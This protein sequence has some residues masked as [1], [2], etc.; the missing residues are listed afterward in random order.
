MLKRM[1]GLGLALTVALTWSAAGLAGDAA[2]PA[3][4]PV[5][6][7]AGVP[8]EA[9]FWMIV[10]SPKASLER[11]KKLAEAFQPGTG[12]MAEL[13]IR[14]ASPWSFAEADEAKP[15]V[16][17]F[18]L[19]KEAG[20]D[21]SWAVAGSLK[22]GTD[23]AA[24]LEKRF[25][26]KPARTEDGVSV[27]LQVQEGA[28][29]DKEIFA[30]AKDGRLVLGDSK[31]LIRSLANCPAPADGAFPAGADI[32][33]GVDVTVL[34]TQY[35]DK[36]EAGL[37][38]LEEGAANAAAMMP[39]AGA[40][41]QGMVV[42]AKVLADKCRVGL[43]EVAQAG[44]RIGLGDTISITWTLQAIP[45]TSF[46]AELAK[47]EKLGL[48]PVGLLHEQG[49]VAMALSLP[50]EYA[51][52]FVEFLNPVVR[53]GLTIEE[54]DQ[55]KLKALDAEATKFTTALSALAKQFDGRMAM[56]LGKGAGAGALGFLAVK[57]PAAARAAMTTIGKLSQDGPFAEVMRKQ[58]QKQT[59][60]TNVRQNG[61]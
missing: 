31:A 45:G 39:G 60:A 51:Q 9:A 35:K 49:T 50:P 22:A 43:K 46:A 41:A 48:P 61:G 1:A 59:F 36:I 11:L 29:P 25:G 57:D 13:G 19:P 37:K 12:A 30:A 7:P 42:G 5:A 10:P 24:V 56:S 4:K 32:L 18:Q 54:A 21:P 38:D 58:G 34:A 16:A 26:G 6:R 40:N 23:G 14:Q 20:A 55:E 53:A 44:V 33:A 2:A 47:M 27:F 3:P 17:V 8:A 28:L 15:I 52:S